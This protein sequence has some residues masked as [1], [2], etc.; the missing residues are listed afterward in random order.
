MGQT[1]V[2]ID[3]GKVKARTTGAKGKETTL[4]LIGKG[5]LPDKV[6]KVCVVG[7]EDPTNAELARDGFVRCVLQGE[8]AMNESQFVKMLWF[9]PAGKGKGGYRKKKTKMAVEDDVQITTPLFK[10]LNPSQ[11]AV[12][13]AMIGKAQPLVVAHGARG[14]SVETATH[15]TPLSF[16]LLGA[17]GTGK[18]STIA[19]ALDHWARHRERAWVIAHSNVGVKNIAESLVKR[20]IDF[21][22]IV[23]QDFYYEWSVYPLCSSSPSGTH[24][25]HVRVSALVPSD[26]HEHHYFDISD[27]LV[28]SDRLAHKST[29]LDALF[30]TQYIVLC[31]LSMLSAASNA[32][33]RV[34][35]L[36]PVERLIVDEASQIDT[37]DFM[38]RAPYNPVCAPSV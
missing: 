25:G 11:Q 20:K 2:Y 35:E 21:K 22:I 10:K 33:N 27:H 19:V 26:R 30:D 36:V 5:K 31:T 9:S 13:R 3:G 28:Q 34:F 4:K 29:D 12:V 24:S 6:K 7:R 16:C 23:S 14:V 17:S 1:V 37:F 18:T 8:G 38:V 32:M 15:L